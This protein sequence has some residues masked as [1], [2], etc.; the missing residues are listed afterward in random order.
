M[1]DDDIATFAT[2]DDVL[3]NKAAIRRMLAE[4]ASICDAIIVIE[5]RYGTNED[6]AD[7]RR[8]VLKVRGDVI[9]QLRGLLAV[10]TETIH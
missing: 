1:T 10:D 8:R 6:I 9:A 2:V 7:A 3:A 4:I 5:A